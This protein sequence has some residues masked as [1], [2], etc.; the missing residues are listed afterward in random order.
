[1]VTGPAP[2]M[3]AASSSSSGIV[4]S[5]PYMTTIQPPAPVQNAIIA[6]MNGRCPGAI[7][8]AKRCEPSTWF[9]R[10]EPGLTAGSSMNSH[11]RTAA[12]PA[13]APG[14]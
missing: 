10:N 7:D 6:K 13:S 2:S 1:M 5:A 9:S 4:F 3:R 14:M 11:T 8:W 12:A